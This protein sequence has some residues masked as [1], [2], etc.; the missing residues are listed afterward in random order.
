MPM[1]LQKNEH[2]LGSMDVSHS[3][4]LPKATLELIVNSERTIK[5]YHAG[6]TF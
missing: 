6:P 3:M 2:N 4:V 1:V 5:K